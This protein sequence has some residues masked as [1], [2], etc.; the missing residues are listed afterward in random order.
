VVWPGSVFGIGCGIGG[1]TGENNGINYAIDW[2]RSVLQTLYW[3]NQLALPFIIAQGSGLE[4][5]GPFLGL[6]LAIL[7][8]FLS[9]N[10]II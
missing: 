7:A 4:A 10:F 5:R 3:P 8:N 9:D 6:H 1:G 2:F